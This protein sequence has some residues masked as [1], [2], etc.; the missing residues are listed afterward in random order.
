[1]NSESTDLNPEMTSAEIA[2]LQALFGVRYF[3]LGEEKGVIYSRHEDPYSF[4]AHFC[5]DEV[6]ELERGDSAWTVRLVGEEGS[7]R[8]T[9]EVVSGPARVEV[10][11]AGMTVVVRGFALPAT[12]VQLDGE[13]TVLPYVNGCST[14]QIIPP[15]RPG[16]PTLQH[17]AIPPYSAEQAHHVHATARVA[18]IL[19]GRGVSVVG[20]EGAQVKTELLPGTLCVL[21]PMSPHHF[22]TPQGEWLHVVPLHVWSSPPGGIE[23]Q[24]PMFSGTFRVG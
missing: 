13:N 1:M 6:I 8:A 3:R 2:R 4:A 16:D 12:T 10:P 24:H 17:L 19:R 14:R 15:P 18:L 23:Y 7:S 21:H 22:E 9:C 20:M 5:T 11:S